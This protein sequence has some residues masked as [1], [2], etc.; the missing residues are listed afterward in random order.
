MVC[1]R[2][3]CKSSSM[4]CAMLLRL[5]ST[6]PITEL[7]PVL[8]LL[9]LL[10]AMLDLDRFAGGAAGALPPVAP[11]PAASAPSCLRGAKVATPDTHRE[12]GRH[13]I[14]SPLPASWSLLYAWR[15]CR[16][17]APNMAASASIKRA[18]RTRG[19]GTL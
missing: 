8:L 2:L 18:A 12:H 4:L 1:G 14:S 19:L 17:T 9:L 16:T 11:V 15:R 6:L 5:P 7:C 10:A 3:W 13:V